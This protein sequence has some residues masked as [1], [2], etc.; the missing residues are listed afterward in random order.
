MRA[1]IVDGDPAALLDLRYQPIF[2]GAVRRAVG[3]QRRCGAGARRRT[4]RAPLAYLAANPTGPRA[5]R[6]SAGPS[7]G[8]GARTAPGAA[9]GL[10]LRLHLTLATLRRRARSTRSPTASEPAMRCSGSGSRSLADRGTPPAAVDAFARRLARAGGA[11]WAARHARSFARQRRAACWTSSRST[12]APTTSHAGG[13]RAGSMVAPVVI[14][15]R[16]GRPRA[17]ALAGAPRRD[18]GARRRTSRSQWVC[19]SL[20]GGQVT[21]RARSDRERARAALSG[22]GDFGCFTA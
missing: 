3:G 5:R 16:R 19:K 12:T 7:L 14:R 2:D 15:G 9:A 20:F 8:G 22:R 21:I 11:A 18:S 4:H 10:D 6:S 17:G 13:A 1:R